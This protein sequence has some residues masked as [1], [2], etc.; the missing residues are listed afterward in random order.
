MLSGENTPIQ[1]DPTWVAEASELVRAQGCPV[2]MP[3]TLTAV[4]LL[5]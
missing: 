5:R 1:T 2:V 3:G 4:E